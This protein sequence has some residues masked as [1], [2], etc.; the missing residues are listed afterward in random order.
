MPGILDFGSLFDDFR[1][2]FGSGEDFGFSDDSGL[3]AVDM[4]GMTPEELA[5]HFGRGVEGFD[6]DEFMK[7]FGQFITPFDDTK[8]NLLQEGFQIGGQV[9]GGQVNKARGGIRS[10]LALSAGA[11]EQ[12]GFVLADYA[13]RMRSLGVGLKQDVLGEYERYQSQTVD[14]FR[15]LAEREVFTEDYWKDTD[16]GGN[17]PIV[18]GGGG[19]DVTFEDEGKCYNLLGQEIPC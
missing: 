8:V 15:Q 13:S 18:G 1:D 19:G 2:R 5:E 6:V 11:E 7:R 12:R 10:N 4:A 9:L 14:F 17:G 3:S 16:T